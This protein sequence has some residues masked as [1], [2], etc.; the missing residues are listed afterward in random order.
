MLVPSPQLLEAVRGIPFGRRFHGA[1]YSSIEQVYHNSAFLARGSH[2]HDKL[3]ARRFPGHL[4]ETV[5]A[6]WRY[7]TSY[8]GVLFLWGGRVDVTHRSSPQFRWRGDIR[9]PA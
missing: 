9:Q 4:K 1:G 3:A 7:R 2:K 8:K 5:P 6:P